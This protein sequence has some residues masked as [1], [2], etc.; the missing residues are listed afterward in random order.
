MAEDDKG[1]D[2]GQGKWDNVSKVI[3]KSGTGPVAS[4]AK[5]G[6]V[7][8]K[9]QAIEVPHQSIQKPDGA[10]AQFKASKIGKKAA[11]RQIE[12]WYE[13]QLEATKHAVHE[14]VRVRKAEASRIEP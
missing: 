1:D 5:A 14:A 13:G 3:G 9:H 11:L 4:R 2:H 6:E 10:I 8:Q 7:L 12:V